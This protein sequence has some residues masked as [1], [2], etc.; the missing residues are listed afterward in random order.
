M[1]LV[2]KYAPVCVLHLPG[3]HGEELR[4][5]NG[6]VP[7]GINLV[8]HVLQL[9]LGGVLAQGPHHLGEV[10]RRRS[11]RRGRRRRRRMWM[12]LTSWY[13]QS[14][15]LH[16]QWHQPPAQLQAKFLFTQLSA[17]LEDLLNTTLVD[18]INS[19]H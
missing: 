17:N 12:Q 10:R 5:V 13:D 18:Q 2:A 1:H 3:H 11:R 4:E 19:K 14:H 9:R 8:D 7:V 16:L 6:S 15:G